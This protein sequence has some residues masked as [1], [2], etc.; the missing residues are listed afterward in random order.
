M[1]K[2]A[3]YIT[4]IIFLV[5]GIGGWLFFHELPRIDGRVD[6]LSEQIEQKNNNATGSFDR[7][8]DSVTN[9]LNN[10]SQEYNLKLNSQEQ[11]IVK[12]E[13]EFLVL[14]TALNSKFPGLNLPALLAISFQKNIP[15]NEVN[16][17]LKL[18]EKD[19]AQVKSYFRSQWHFNEQEMN[20]VF[21]APHKPDSETP[22]FTKPM[23]EKKEN[24]PIN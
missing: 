1:K 7:K 9:Q 18:W 15:I 16:T 22:T 14:T 24:L 21:Q 8:I 4:I 2:D 12:L 13:K 19:P 6:K 23:L 17:V 10:F 3:L 20:R 5:G 11:R